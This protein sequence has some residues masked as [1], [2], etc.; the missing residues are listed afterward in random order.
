MYVLASPVAG[1]AAAAAAL[2]PP[3]P[4]SLLLL[5]LLLCRY[6]LLRAFHKTHNEKQSVETGCAPRCI[7]G[8]DAAAAQQQ[9]S[10]S[11]AAAAAQQQQQQ[12]R[13]RR[14]R[15]WR[16]RGSSSGQLPFGVSGWLLCCVSI[17]ERVCALSVSVHP[18]GP[19]LP[20]LRG[21]GLRI[22]LGACRPIVWTA[23]ARMNLERSSVQIVRSSGKFRAVF[24]KVRSI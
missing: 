2:P 5:L 3:P 24:C 15:R 19:S 6:S 21:F 7:A 14:R 8:R 12:Q 11:T 23:E 1:P 16:R 9:H 4:P 17:A 18:G 20:W 13:R 22:K 10:S